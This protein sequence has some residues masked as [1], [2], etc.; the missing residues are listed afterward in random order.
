MK[1]STN[2]QTQDKTLREE[3]VHDGWVH[4]LPAHCPQ[5]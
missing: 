2:Q 3:R 5:F 4:R 1:T